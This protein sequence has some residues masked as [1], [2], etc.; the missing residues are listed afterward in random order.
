MPKQVSFCRR[1]RIPQPIHQESRSATN[2]FLGLLRVKMKLP[3]Q[4]LLSG[5]A[6][7]SEILAISL[8]SGWWANRRGTATDCLPMRKEV[9]FNASHDMINTSTNM[10]DINAKPGSYTWQRRQYSGSATAPRS[11][12][13]EHCSASK[14]LPPLS[15]LA[16]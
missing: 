6:N 1:S 13:S 10:P 12:Q 5:W 4:P 14:S 16:L 15:T 7:A 3:P 9:L 11:R 8:M 2:T